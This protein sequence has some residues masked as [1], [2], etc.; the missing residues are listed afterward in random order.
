[1]WDLGSGGPGE[2][3]WDVGF[4]L[5]RAGRPGP[6]LEKR[7]VKLSGAGL[8]SRHAPENRRFQAH[9]R[10]ACFPAHARTTGL[11]R[12]KPGKAGALRAFS[13]SS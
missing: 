13:N 2:G 3:R 12:A 1:M 6:E 4:R 9:A 8:K 10:T 5:R 7:V 11:G